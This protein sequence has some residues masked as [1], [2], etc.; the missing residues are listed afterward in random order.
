MRKFLMRLLL[1]LVPAF[2]AAPVQAAED[3][4]AAKPADF[5]TVAQD[6]LYG[7][8]VVTLYARDPACAHMVIRKDKT[9][10][11]ALGTIH[12][13]QNVIRPK[14]PAWEREQLQVHP[15][16]FLF[17]PNGSSVVAFFATLHDRDTLAGQLIVPSTGVGLQ[18]TARRAV[19]QQSKL[20]Q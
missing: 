2:V 14:D 12:R 19:I 18:M 10:F 20:P 15:T 17:S 8:W 1:A 7:S 11:W 5:E 9:I 16:G 3:C 13:G 4:D 6:G